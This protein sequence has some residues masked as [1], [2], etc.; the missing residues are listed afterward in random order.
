MLKGSKIY[1]R[2]LEPADLDFLYECENNTAI[3]NVTNTFIPFSKNT[4][5]KYI[6]SQ[7][8]IYADKQLRLV[9]VKN[10]SRIPVGFIDLFDFDA[11]HLRAGVGILIS[12]EEN[13]NKGYAGEAIEIISNYAK[14]TLG[15]VN[16]FCNILANNAAS[17]KIFEANGFEKLAIKPRWH[18]CKNE[19]L[20]ELFY[21]K[22]LI[23]D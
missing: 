1:L 9:I 19:W 23:H 3:W 13:K 20:D 4:L 2:A 22:K 21:I 16:L 7:Q 5:Q 10:D 11:Y 14:N 8:D 15:L 6:N 18:R 12:G 17:I